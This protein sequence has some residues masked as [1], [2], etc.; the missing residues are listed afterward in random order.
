MSKLSLIYVT[1]ANLDEA[2]KIAKF[3]V[4]EKKV[5]CANILPGATSI[6]HWEG[7]LEE[8][9]ECVLIAKT[10]TSLVDD[11]I[12]V[13]KKLHSYSCPCIVSLSIDNGNPDFLAWIEKET[14][15]N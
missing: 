9:T 15:K 4:T 7:K 1:V 11:V 8:T 10:K 2:K 6:Y 13:V 14:I 3:L 5:A 12:T